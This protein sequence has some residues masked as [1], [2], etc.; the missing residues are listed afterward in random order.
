M[1]IK[2]NIAVAR[3]ARDLGFRYVRSADIAVVSVVGERDSP[4]TSL[5]DVLQAC[6]SQLRPRLHR[7]LLTLP[8]HKVF[9]FAATPF[10]DNPNV[11]ARRRG[12]WGL[13]SFRWLP[14]DATRSSVVEVKNEDGIR[15]AGIAQIPEVA[16][17]DAADFVRTNDSA[18]LF[19][20]SHITMS[21]SDV[22]SMFALA[23]PKG[24][25]G[26][27][28]AVLADGAAAQQDILLRVSGGFDDREAAVDALMSAELLGSLE[29]T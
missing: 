12:I 15:F 29:S 3:S 13:E 9:L 6:M 16:L 27:D 4:E 14:R 11:V 5:T 28:W 20:S 26:A 25:L 10:W 23:F 7:W 21:E 24:Q 17:A 2:V 19:C 1:T 8:A 18:V 22:R